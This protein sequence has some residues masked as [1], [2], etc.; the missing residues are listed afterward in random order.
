MCSVAEDVERIDYFSFAI[1]SIYSIGSCMYP[2]TVLELRRLISLPEIFL[3]SAEVRIN[4]GSAK[5]G[6]T[7]CSFHGKRCDVEP[8]YVDPVNE[9]IEV[10]LFYVPQYPTRTNRLCPF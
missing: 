9:S 8:L 2:Y 3:P 10:D 7:V 6:M 1:V 4:R 5:R